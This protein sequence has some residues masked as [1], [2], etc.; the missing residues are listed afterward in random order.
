MPA[1]IDALDRLHRFVERYPNKKA[2]ADA[3]GITPPYLND[4]INMRRDIS[5]Q[6]LEK[7]GLKRVTRI[8]QSERAK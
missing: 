6:M 5:D 4:L 7:L 8:I 3:L 2:A 1:E